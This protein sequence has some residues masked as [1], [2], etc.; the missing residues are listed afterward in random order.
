MFLG[1]N[2]R[3]YLHQLCTF[4]CSLSSR[5]FMTQTAFWFRKISEAIK[6]TK[7]AFV[8]MW[9]F[10]RTSALSVRHP[11]PIPCSSVLWLYFPSPCLG[12]RWR[13]AESN[14]A[15]WGL[16]PTRGGEFLCP[17]GHIC[18]GVWHTLTVSASLSRATPAALSPESVA[19]AGLSGQPSQPLEPGCF[20]SHGSEPTCGHIPCSGLPQHSRCQLVFPKSYGI[21]AQHSFQLKNIFKTFERKYIAFFLIIKEA[22]CMQKI[23]PTLKCI[24]QKASMSYDSATQ[25]QP[26]LFY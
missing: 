17:C 24:T 15:A 22:H 10:G 4:F 25:R 13:K 14:L 11:V 26:C 9:V 23:W 16:L 20:I 19:L 2:V 18:W 8:I 21:S 3:D 6:H 7:P 1:A 5:Y 12:R